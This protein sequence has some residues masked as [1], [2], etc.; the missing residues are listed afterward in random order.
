[1]REGAVRA[2]HL[3][4][5]ALSFALVLEG[6]DLLLL[7]VRD[8]RLWLP[9]GL[10]SGLLTLPLLWR[11]GVGLVP[12]WTMPVYAGA[13]SLRRLGAYHLTCSVVV[14]WLWTYPTLRLV[15]W[16]HESRGLSGGATVP[17][18]T[19]TVPADIVSLVGGLLLSE[20]LFFL[21]TLVVFARLSAFRT[22]VDL[23]AVRARDLFRPGVV[24][25]GGYLLAGLV[26]SVASVLATGV[27]ALG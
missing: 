12:P 20:L 15:A 1:M 8:V 14:A 16:V 24:G 17:A 18:G 9:V 11:R 22:D 4:A 21:P 26:V 10:A 19:G 6:P 7:A 25:I 3:C 23:H 13:V 5:V 2:L 27:A